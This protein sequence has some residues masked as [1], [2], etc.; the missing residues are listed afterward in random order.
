MVS[1]VYSQANNVAKQAIIH[2]FKYAPKSVDSIVHDGAGTSYKSK[3]IT[4]LETNDMDSYQIMVGALREAGVS[5]SDIKAKIAD[6]YRDEYKNTYKLYL[7]AG[8]DSERRRAYD[9][10]LERLENF[11]GDTGFNFD[12][13]NWIKQVESTY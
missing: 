8:N 12:F 4:A 10:E 7:Y 9:R 11:L 13:G 5:D 2:D 3:M 1:A 6:K